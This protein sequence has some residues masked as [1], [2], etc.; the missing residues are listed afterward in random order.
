M[1]PQEKTKS[2]RYQIC[3]AVS[4]WKV[5]LETCRIRLA[6]HGLR[7]LEDLITNCFVHDRAGV[8]CLTTKGK[9]LILDGSDLRRRY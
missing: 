6:L 5:D 4:R 2:E 3:M 1:T 8:V 7:V 9:N